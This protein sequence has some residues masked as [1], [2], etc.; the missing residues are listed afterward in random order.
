VNEVPDLER[1]WHHGCGTLDA[2]HEVAWKCAAGH[3]VALRYCSAHIGAAMERAFAAAADDD[4]LLCAQCDGDREIRP[5][6]E[7]RAL[8]S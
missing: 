8:R 5:V 4:P 7:G 3:R 6:L 1:C 2:P